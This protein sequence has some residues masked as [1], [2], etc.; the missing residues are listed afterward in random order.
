MMHWFRTKY[1][2]HVNLAQKCNITKIGWNVF[3]G[4]ENSLWF[5]GKLYLVIKELTDYKSIC[6]WNIQV[7]DRQTLRSD[8]CESNVTE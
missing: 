8:Q 6:A 7:I 5:N 4:N 2:C 1:E 3:V